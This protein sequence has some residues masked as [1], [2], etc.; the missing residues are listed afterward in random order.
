MC[1]ASRAG[2][3]ACETALDLAEVVA[4]AIE[5]SHPLLV[6][7]RHR[8]TVQLP[9]EPIV[10]EAD[11][12][13]LTQVILNLLNNAAKYTEEGGDIVLTVEQ[14]CRGRAARSRHRHGHSS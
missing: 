8:F 6:E 12:T 13:R 9:N 3:S 1:R 7:R 14:R 10:V 11:P 2:R 4:Q 5:T